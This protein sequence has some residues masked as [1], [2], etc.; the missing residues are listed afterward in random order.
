MS[1]E[2]FF[3]IHPTFLTTEKSIHNKR[4]YF[5]RNSNFRHLQL[6]YGLGW[7]FQDAKQKINNNVI[8]TLCN[9]LYFYRRTW[10]YNTFRV[11]FFLKLILIRWRMWFFDRFYTS[12]ITFI[13]FIFCIILP[14]CP[15]LET[16]LTFIHFYFFF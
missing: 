3:F 4:N 9:R 1:G 16:F 7:R 2:R 8:F 15:F 5:T 11:F 13:H 6:V 10:M 12:E 14:K